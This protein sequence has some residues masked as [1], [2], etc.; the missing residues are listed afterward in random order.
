M[1]TFILLPI[2][3]L[4]VHPLLNLLPPLPLEA[5]GMLAII[6]GLELHG[7]LSPVVINDRD[8]IMQDE[9]RCLVRAAL[10]A[11]LT[12]LPVIVRPDEDAPSLILT[13]LCG[14][15]HLTKSALAYL[16]FPLMEA[17]RDARLAR[18]TENLKSGVSA[19][20]SR[21]RTQCTFGETV[22]TLSDK[23]GFGKR[24]YFL[25]R[26]VHGTFRDNP[27]FK[28]EMEPRL[29]SGEESLQGVLAIW[30]G[31]TNKGGE[32]PDRSDQM[33][34]FSDCF[35]SLRYHFKRTWKSLPDADRQRVE[36]EVRETVAEMPPE[37][38]AMFMR[39]LRDAEKA[40]REAGQT[41]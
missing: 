5:P 32:R 14:R 10:K 41:V 6:E 19:S 24:F 2:D 40:A 28:A 11:G 18:R 30:N 38:R 23:L 21:T 3:K 34:F 12:E 35:G 33:T 25:A 1:I 31:R 27:E 36:P 4:T 20:N 13:G 22:E 17:G 26:N 16:A 7:I 9:G 39:E 37:V 15:R 29:V 8:E